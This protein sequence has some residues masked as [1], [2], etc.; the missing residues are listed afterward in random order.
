V[1]QP[2]QQASISNR[3]VGT[4]MDVSAYCRE[5]EAYLCRKN[6]GHLIRIAG[7][8]FEQV[9]GWAARG[10]PLKVA[11]RGIDVCVA[12]YHAK[13]PRRRPVRIEF[14]EADILDE[15]DRWR[16]AVGVTGVLTGSAESA[17]EPGGARRPGLARHLA[18]T[19]AAL[20]AVRATRAMTP[21]FGASVDAC[22]D[23]L[24]VL[25]REARGA[26]GA[27]RARLLA[28][29]AEL[30][31]QLASAARVEIGGVWA[32]L[33]REAEEELQPFRARMDRDAWRQAVDTGADRL[34]RERLGLPRLELL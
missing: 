29:L 13:G 33:V 25:Q 26:R 17:D 2:D 23:A 16:R 18:S 22:L 24:D 27:A 8:A 10:V 5:I 21:E 34:V 1:P 14:C 19:L 28:R 15:F 7:P 30:D 4:T 11:F 12:R 6:E 20:T 9:C 32:E 31:R 3:Q